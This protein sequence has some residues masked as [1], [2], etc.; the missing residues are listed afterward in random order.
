MT[1]IRAP[2]V[3][4]AQRP[5]N[6]HLQIL[7]D[8][9]QQSQMGLALGTNEPA[10]RDHLFNQILNTLQHG[11]SRPVN[12]ALANGALAAMYGIAPRDEIE[13][14][15]AAQ[16]IATHVLAMDFLGRA[17]R[18]EYRHGLNDFGHL[19]NKLLRT[20]V[21]QVEALQRYRGKGQQK[22]TVEHVHVHRG[23]QAIV[24]HVETTPGGGGTGER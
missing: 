9:R 16:M 18:A 1:P 5:D 12:D 21:A 3:Q 14:L 17:A 7:A 13:R 15:L 10:F 4:I 20:Y 6:G 11:K 8:D 24:G 22:V 2:R 23:G 19:A